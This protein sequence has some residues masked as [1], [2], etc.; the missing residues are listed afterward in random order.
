MSTIYQ[1]VIL[2]HASQPHN[3][4]KL[5]SATHTIKKD[6]PLCGDVIQ[7]E[8][9]VKN[10]V[11]KDIRFAGSGCAISKASASLLTDY[12]KG[13]K[14]IQLRKFSKAGMMKL[15]GITLGPNRTKCAL[16]AL[17]ALHA[18]LINDMHVRYTS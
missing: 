4:G 8:I 14:I 7:M 10:G 12:A 5:P 18:L 17:E 6:N 9:E 11:I 1:E 16:L 2:S 13:K 3:F 15:L